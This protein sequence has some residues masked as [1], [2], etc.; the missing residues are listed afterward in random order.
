MCPLSPLTS[1]GMSSTG[2]SPQ[3][4]RILQKDS[5]VVDLSIDTQVLYPF[6]KAL[7][8]LSHITIGLYRLY[9]SMK[10]GTRS[11]KIG[12]VRDPN[13]QKIQGPERIEHHIFPIQLKIYYCDY[14]N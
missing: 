2:L 4:I 13:A 7:L 6:N 12:P 3:K 11:A 8:A 14:I 10:K 1:L 5:L 9:L